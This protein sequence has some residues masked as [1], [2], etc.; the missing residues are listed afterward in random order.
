MGK[1]SVKY[2]LLHD[3]P[4]EDK[5]STSI[6][7]TPDIAIQEGY[8]EQGDIVWKPAEESFVSEIISMAKIRAKKQ[9]PS[10]QVSSPQQHN[11][12]ASSDH[13]GVADEDKDPEDETDNDSTSSE[14]SDAEDNSLKLL[15]D[16]QKSFLERYHDPNEEVHKLREVTFVYLLDTGGQSSFQDALPML[17]DF[18]CNFVQTFNASCK[19]TDPYADTYCRDGETEVRSQGEN[20]QTPWELMQQSLMAAY[21]MSF[22]HKHHL[23]QFGGQDPE[24][25]IFIV[26]T[27]LDKVVDSVER[28]ELLSSHDKVLRQTTSK[29]YHEFREFPQVTYKNHR[30]YA[31]LDSQFR[32]ESDHSKKVLSDLREQLSDE[33]ACMKLTI[34]K[35]WYCLQLIIRKID[36]KMWRYTDLKQFCID[37]SYIAENQADE[38][39]QALLSLFHSL[40][41][42]VY[43]NLPNLDNEEDWICSE[44]TFFYILF[45]ISFKG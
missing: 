4:R 36:K 3:E 19:L 10:I 33:K 40:G 18:P 28:E 32:A 45:L 21:T 38:Q 22:K 13:T 7:E 14:L 2:S 37:E 44:A 8:F 29:V 1:T 30:S 16:A 20:M 11:P 24:L 31:L 9:N 43:F 41:F 42:F 5:T 27:H 6:L 39:L 15:Y 26:G 25:R 23:A 12:T 35:L 17:L 34:P